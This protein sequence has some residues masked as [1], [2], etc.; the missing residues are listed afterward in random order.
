MRISCCRTIQQRQIK[1]G[2]TAVAAQLTATHSACD[3]VLMGAAVEKA[4]HG[5]HQTKSFHPFD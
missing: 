3:H 5:S 4:G 2:A 1:T